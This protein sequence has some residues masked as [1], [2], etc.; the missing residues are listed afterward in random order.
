[1]SPWLYHLL[2]DAGYPATCLEIRH[3]SAAIKSQPIK[4][5]RNDALAIA[6]L[7]RL[8]WYKS[9]FV[10][11]P[12]MQKLRMLLCHRQQLNQQ[13]QNLMNVIR[14]SLKSFGI[15]LGSVQ[16][17]DFASVVYTKVGDDKLMLQAISPLISALEHM[18]ESFAELDK[19]VRKHAHEDAICK[20]LM[21]LMYC[22]QSG[23]ST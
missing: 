2:N 10:K 17:K 4:T 7:M 13:I 20:K 3:T 15:K 12:E 23:C 21:E 22:S 5:D 1:M 9:T 18:E 11:S 19:T 6:Q 16:K 14:G 8:G